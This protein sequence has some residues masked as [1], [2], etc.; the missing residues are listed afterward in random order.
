M[1]NYPGAR[2]V[3]VVGLLLANAAV[4]SHEGGVENAHTRGLQRMPRPRPEILEIKHVVFM[5]MKKVK[6]LKCAQLSR[7]IKSS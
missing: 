5:Y 2:R 3:V 7:G 1:L 6:R 4:P